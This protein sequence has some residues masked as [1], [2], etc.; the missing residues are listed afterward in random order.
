MRAE[1][2]LQ[3]EILDKYCALRW[4]NLINF[5]QG[6]DLFSCVTCLSKGASCVFF[7]LLR[8]AWEGPW[9]TSGKLYIWMMM[10]YLD[11]HLGFFRV[12]E[13]QMLERCLQELSSVCTSVVLRK[14]L[15]VCAW[16]ERR[17]SSALSNTAGYL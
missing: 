7:L 10:L 2:S 13:K 17:P 5:Y 8:S 11:C 14:A 16:R 9:I 3:N 1:S 15:C 12:T 6:E 4:S